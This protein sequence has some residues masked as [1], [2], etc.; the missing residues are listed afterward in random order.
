MTSPAPISLTRPGTLRLIL[1]CLGYL[2]A[3]WRLT[4]GAYPGCWRSP[5]W[6]SSFHSSSGGA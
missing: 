6:R 4:A 5:A 2:R 3:Y 1:R